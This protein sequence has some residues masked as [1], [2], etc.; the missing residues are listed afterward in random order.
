[1]L[2]KSALQ[3]LFAASAAAIA[4][5]D[6]S[7]ENA[8][9]SGPLPIMY[10]KCYRI[11]TDDRQWMGKRGSGYQGWDLNLAQSGIYEVCQHRVD[12]SCEYDAVR[13]VQSDEDF[14]L[15]AFSG[16]NSGGPNLVA[17]T[18][19]SYLGWFYAAYGGWAR[20][21]WHFRGKAD[22]DLGTKPCAIHT[23]GHNGDMAKGIRDHAQSWP[24]AT[25]DESTVPLWF[26]EV[27]CPEDAKA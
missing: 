26:H 16:S 7:A 22:C 11:Q 5:P 6:Q 4:I 13:T 23:G 10:G 2:I 17:A 8:P 3:A 21:I 18:N 25:P 1:M 20:Y 27:E 9:V 15:W 19:P 24:V 14:F 12:G